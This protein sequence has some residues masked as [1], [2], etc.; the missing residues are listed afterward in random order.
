LKIFDQQLGNAA[1]DSPDALGGRVLGRLAAATDA[2]L[3]SVRELEALRVPALAAHDYVREA[4]AR[5]PGVVEVSARAWSAD[6]TLRALF[7]R[8][9][10]PALTVNG[11]GAVRTWLEAHPSADCVALLTFEQHDRRVPPSILASDVAGDDVARTHVRFSNPRVMA[12]AADETSVREELVGRAIDHLALRA[13]EQAGM[14]RAEADSA[15]R[16]CDARLRLARRRGMGFTAIAMDDGVDAG[17]DEVF[18]RELEASVGA[19]ENAPEAGVMERLIEALHSVL[20]APHEQMRIE[21]C[22]FA[23]DAMNLVAAAGPGAVIP[24]VAMLQLAGHA[25]YVV[26]VARFPRPERRSG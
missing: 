26:V 16:L 11:D 3:A 20:S 22:E 7:A 18:E 6:A 19:L 9:D 5:V 12:P 21:A 15:A 4:V 17:E 13:L 23:L 1:G 14:D 2:R 25:P 24:R 8:G 10:D